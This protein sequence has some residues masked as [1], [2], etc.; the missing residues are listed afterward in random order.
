MTSGP[1]WVSV[2][3]HTNRRGS[4]M[5][6]TKLSDADKLLMDIYHETGD[7]RIGTYFASKGLNLRNSEKTAVGVLVNDFVRC[8]RAFNYYS[9]QKD[10]FQSMI[11][12]LRDAKPNTKFQSRHFIL[13]FEEKFNKGY[14]VEPFEYTQIT[15]IERPK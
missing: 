9:G 2:L 13:S 1:K 8:R 11:K 10:H 3:L 12:E 7:S 14:T 15:Y 4:T 5:S 6:V